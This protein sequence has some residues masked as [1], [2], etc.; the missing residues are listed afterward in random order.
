MPCPT[1]ADKMGFKYRSQSV[2]RAPRFVRIEFVH[3]SRQ[4][5]GVLTQVFFVDNTGLIDNESHDARVA[6]FGR[7]VFHDH[8]IA[9]QVLFASIPVRVSSPPWRPG[10]SALGRI[11]YSHLKEA[12]HGG[13]VYAD[14]MD[15]CSCESEMLR[16]K[17]S[18]NADSFR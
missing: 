6:I 3:T 5:F 10:G 1:R 9:P 2:C 14:S 11:R 13:G 18:L 16:R 12:A 15:F 7:V 4:L 8:L 17:C